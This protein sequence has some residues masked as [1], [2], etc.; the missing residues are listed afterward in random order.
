[1][2]WWDVSMTEEG[3]GWWEEKEVDTARV[4]SWI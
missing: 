1:M 3:G 2:N 4:Y